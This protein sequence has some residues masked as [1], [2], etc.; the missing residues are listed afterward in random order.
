M[1]LLAFDAERQGD[2]PQAED[3]SFAVDHAESLVPPPRSALGLLATAGSPGSGDLW[4]QRGRKP[5]CITSEG[6]G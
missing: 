2:F 3:Q 1:R 5:L 6:F 4:A